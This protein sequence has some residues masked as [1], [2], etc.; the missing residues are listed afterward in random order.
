[1][2][3]YKV[4]CRAA[5][6]FEFVCAENIYVIVLYLDKFTK[7]IHKIHFDSAVR[8]VSKVCSFIASTY[9]SKQKNPIKKLLIGNKLY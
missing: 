4:S 6:V 9:Y 5:W 3:D 8:P 2:I 1:M 7:N